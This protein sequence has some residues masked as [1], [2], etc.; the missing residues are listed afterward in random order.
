MLWDPTLWL[1]RRICH[2][3]DEALQ[4]LTRHDWP[5]NIR[6]LE[7]CIE[8]AAALAR[9]DTITLDDLPE[10]IRSA[11]IVSWSE[12][13]GEHLLIEEALRRFTGDKT[14][15]APYPGWHRRK[16]NRDVTENN[17]ELGVRRRN[18]A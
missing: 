12:K 15:A 5:G 11:T 14:R 16:L 6:E 17:V 18:K 7:N 1:G 3:S 9:T 4:A 13:K 2:V 8:R 10:S